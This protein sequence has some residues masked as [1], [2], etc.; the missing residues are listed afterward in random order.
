MWTT[1]KRMKWLLLAILAL[2]VV[3]V[4]WVLRS[5]F[6]GPKAEGPSRLPPVP[7]KLQEKVDKAEEEA[8]K[9][10]VEAKVTAETDKKELEEIGKIADGKERRKRLADKLKQ[11]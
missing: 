11:L 6:G 4:T 9:A 2:G 7:P 10:R 8:L 5:L 3:V 1:F